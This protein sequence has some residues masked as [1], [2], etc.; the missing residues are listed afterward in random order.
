MIFQTFFDKISGRKNKIMN[1][2]QV[3]AFAITRWNTLYLYIA[4][5]AIILL[6]TPTQKSNVK[7][8][9]HIVN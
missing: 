2:T 4:C 1:R 3:I 5:D 8:I 9:N 6:F 7:H